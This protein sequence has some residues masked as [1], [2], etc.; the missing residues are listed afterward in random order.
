MIII[1]IMGGFASQLN[2]YIFGYN[3][4][5]F[6]GAELGLDISDYYRGYFRPLSLCYL[7]LPDCKVFT[8]G[9]KKKDFKRLK[10]VRNNNDF[11]DML[12]NYSNKMIII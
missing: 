1:K 11:A 5:E 6:L 4:A 3:I 10:Y 8:S 12:I 9:I 2:K 7:A